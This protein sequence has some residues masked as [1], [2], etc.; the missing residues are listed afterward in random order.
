MNKR[1]KMLLASSLV[2]LI[3]RISEHY[4]NLTL[5]LSF[6]FCFESWKFWDL[7][8]YFRLI[9]NDNDEHDTINK[10]IFQAQHQNSASIAHPKGFFM[11]HTWIMF[12][13]QLV[14]F[15]HSTTT[16]PKKKCMLKGSYR[17][18][19]SKLSPYQF[20]KFMFAVP[21]PSLLTPLYHWRWIS[22]ESLC[23][24]FMLFSD[25]INLLVSQFEWHKKKKFFYSE[26]TKDRI[27]S[28][29]TDDC[30]ICE[31][32]SSFS[33]FFY[34]QWTATRSN[35]ILIFHTYLFTLIM[36]R[37]QKEIPQIISIRIQ[38]NHITAM[39]WTK[40]SRDSSTFPGLKC[41]QLIGWL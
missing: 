33:C 32:I 7:I 9:V 11:R 35:V 15:I 27:C 25:H 4:L 41:K 10:T 36:K 37:S 21:P 13:F 2:K 19:C 8:E 3:E 31:K 29:N 22:M 24:W 18:I 26:T 34:E 39:L 40:V 1:E 28:S 16:Y 38:S 17:R 6:C 23:W 30:K 14:I 12:F 5:D 20:D